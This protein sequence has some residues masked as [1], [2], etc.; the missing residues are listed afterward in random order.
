MAK[1]NT[2]RRAAM[3]MARDAWDELSG[4]QKTALL[5]ARPVGT[6]PVRHGAPLVGELHC[7]RSPTA[8]ALAAAKC[9][10]ITSEFI[11]DVRFAPLTLWGLMVR[12]AGLA[13]RAEGQR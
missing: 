5:C 4:A 11:G 1:K 10:S 2:N 9:V 13:A 8:R 3:A 7:S 12:E 6:Q